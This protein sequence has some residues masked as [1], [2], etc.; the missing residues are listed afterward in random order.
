MRRLVICLLALALLGSTAATAAAAPPLVW[1]TDVKYHGYKLLLP[2]NWR[3]R[4][5]SYPSDHST[6]LWYDPANP[7][8]KM[9]ITMSGCV[10]CVD[11][12]F[13]PHRP[14]PKGELP[15]DAT[16]LYWISP[17]KLAFSGYVTDDPYPENG[18]VIVLQQQHAVAGSAIVQLWLPS[19]Q[20]ALATRILNS[21]SAHA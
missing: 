20:H 10:G 5:A 1:R 14:N 12:N 6:Y 4:D 13:D 7:L 9:I 17:W 11:T 8:R 18:L 21:F 16:G 19:S 15:I 3:Y 2:S